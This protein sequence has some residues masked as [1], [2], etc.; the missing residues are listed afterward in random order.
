[1][2]GIRATE[3]GMVTGD[4]G[5][6]LRYATASNAIDANA[7]WRLESVYAGP[8]L[9]VAACSFEHMSRPSRPTALAVEELRW[10]DSPASVAD[11][12]PSLERGL[13]GLR[14][15][16]RRLLASGPGAAGVEVL[17]TAMR[18]RG[19]HAAIAHIGNTRAYMLRGGE[20]TQLTQDHTYGQLLLEAGQI[21]VDQL[22]SDPQHQ[23]V[24]VRWIDG[25]SAEPA[26]II[27]HEAAI[28]DRYVLCTGRI[29]SVM[30]AGAFQYIVSNK[31]NSVGEV[32][33]KLV[34]V[35]FLDPRRS[36]GCVVCDVVE[37]SG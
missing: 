4:D 15:A 23:S 22:G 14:D 18:W 9:L 29:E 20:L 17:L 32:A 26:D 27:T 31:E 33:D 7:E 34:D 36:F 30:S 21:T 37:R 8:H 24:I 3:A 1:M 25:E 10:L 13:E 35:A 12:G 6:V 28:G 2:S 5:V 16:L 19:R 11:L